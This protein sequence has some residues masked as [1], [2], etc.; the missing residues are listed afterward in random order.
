MKKTLLSLSILSLGIIS[1]AQVGVGTNDP[2][3]TLDVVGKPTDTSTPDGVI[4]PRIKR[5]ELI[6]KNTI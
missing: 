6:A 1:H 5:T 2:K 3:A 4:A